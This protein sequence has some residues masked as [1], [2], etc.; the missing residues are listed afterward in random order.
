MLKSFS[1]SKEVKSALKF[2]KNKVENVKDNKNTYELKFNYWLRF[3]VN[4]TIEWTYF[5][6]IWEL[7]PFSRCERVKS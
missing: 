4:K 2:Q 3:F 6:L 7:N 1:P 5:Y